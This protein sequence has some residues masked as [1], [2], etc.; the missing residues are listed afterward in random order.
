MSCYFCATYQLHNSSTDCAGECSNPQKT[1]QVVEI[2]MKK[3]FV[4]FVSDVISEVGFWPFWLM[5]PGLGPN[6]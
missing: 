3:K 4:F 2:A 1:Q 5:L 6:R